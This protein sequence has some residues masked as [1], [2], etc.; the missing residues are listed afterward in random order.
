LG[1]VTSS[2][3]SP[4]LAIEKRLAIGSKRKN[5][6]EPTGTAAIGLVW[7]YNN[8]FELDSEGKEIIGTEDEPVRI[9]VE[10]YREDAEGKPMGSPVIGY[11]TPEGISPLLLP[12]L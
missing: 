12:K 8:P 6:N 4:N 7:L 11:I 1:S 5:V 9:H 3:N 2:I 10:F